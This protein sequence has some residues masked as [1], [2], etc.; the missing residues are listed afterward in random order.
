MKAALP[1]NLYAV[2]LLGVLAATASS[3]LL[4]WWLPV[5]IGAG[6][7]F[8]N[9]WA[10]WAIHRHRTRGRVLGDALSGQGLVNITLVVFGVCIAFYLIGWWVPAGFCT[11]FLADN[12]L[13][14]WGP[15]QEE[16]GAKK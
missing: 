13:G 4:G 16:E 7:L 14:A 3:F 12:I 2:A 5:G 11:G 9:A 10:L 6:L 8:N 15:Y 1:P